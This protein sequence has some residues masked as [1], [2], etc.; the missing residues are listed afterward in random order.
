MAARVKAIVVTGK[1]KSGAGKR[2]WTERLPVHFEWLPLHEKGEGKSR[3]LKADHKHDRPVNASSSR[4]K[5]LASFE[6]GPWF[7]YGNGCQKV[8]GRETYR[9]GC[10]VTEAGMLPAQ[11][12]PGFFFQTLVYDLAEVQASFRGRA[13]HGISYS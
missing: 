11:E 12:V 9:C 10:P 8:E 7:T 2:N 3:K 5:F 4:F 1:N 6:D 13:K